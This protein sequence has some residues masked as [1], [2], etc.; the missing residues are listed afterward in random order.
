MTTDTNKLKI[1]LTETKKKEDFGVVVPPEDR[2]KIQFFENPI[3]L[4]IGRIPTTKTPLIPTKIQVEREGELFDMTVRFLKR[5]NC[6]ISMFEGDDDIVLSDSSKKIFVALL[7]ALYDYYKRNDKDTEDLNLSLQPKQIYKC[8]Y[9]ELSDD[10]KKR[11]EQLK[12]VRKYILKFWKET[13]SIRVISKYTTYDKDGKKIITEFDGGLYDLSTYTRKTDGEGRVLSEGFP[14]NPKF[15]YS[16]VNCNHIMQ[17]PFTAFSV[18]GKNA[19]SLIFDL[20]AHSREN[21]GKK[22]Y[23]VETVLSHI[24]D[25]QKF[26]YGNFKRDI[27]EKILKILDDSKGLALRSYKFVDSEG[28][29]LDL[30]KC[31][32]EEWINSNLVWEQ[33]IPSETTALIGAKQEL[34]RKLEN[35]RPRA[36]KRR[37]SKK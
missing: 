1:H 2:G 34:Q 36:S 17:M 29:E 12:E 37:A 14:V 18:T 16:L 27:K 10:P 6:Q 20:Y 11:K 26:N 7:S 31:S 22:E 28:K 4:A 8:F 5:G 19:F 35:R 15:Y 21:K 3:S 30:D 25:K 24:Y 23:R 32:N 9:E 33:L 13:K